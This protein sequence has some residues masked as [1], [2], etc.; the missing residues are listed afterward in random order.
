MRESWLQTR[1][2]GKK[3]FILREMLAN[4]SITFFAAFGALAMD[5]F[6]NPSPFSVRSILSDRTVSVALILL[7]I[8]L[9]GGYL[10]A[11]WR[12]TDFEK[13]YPEN[14]LPPWR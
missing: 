12:W 4:C 11:R 5:A 9:L 7:P 8:L 1:A 3:R 14:S 6:R 13:K 10:S 2:Q